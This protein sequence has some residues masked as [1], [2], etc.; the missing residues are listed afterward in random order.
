MLSMDVEPLFVHTVED[1][2]RRSAVVDEYEALLAGGLLR[3]LLMD[4]HPLVDQVNARYRIKLRFFI[5]GPTRYEELVLADRPSFWSLGDG[6]DPSLDHP[7]GLSAPQEATRDQLLSR[8]VMVVKDSRVS[9]RD[10]IDQLAHIE[11]AV[12]SGKPRDPREAM[13]KQVERNLYIGGLP[14]GV[15]QV[16]SI[17]RVVVR[18]LTPLYRAVVESE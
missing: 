11:G 13:L 6:I 7:P 4:G 10:L 17:A 16:Q 15:R 3:K 8:G 5:N 2:K 12:H 9:V 14:A 18:G 1:L